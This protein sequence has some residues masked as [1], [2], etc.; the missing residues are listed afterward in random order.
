MPRPIDRLPTHD[1]TQPPP[2]MHLLTT[3]PRCQPSPSSS[4][5]PELERGLSPPPPLTPPRPKVQRPKF[6]RTLSARPSSTSDADAPNAWETSPRAAARALRGWFGTP[7]PPHS[8]NAGEQEEYR[9]RYLG[10]GRAWAG[11]LRAVEDDGALDVPPPRSPAS[12]PR[13]GEESTERRRRSDPKSAHWD[14]AMRAHARALGYSCP[15]SPSDFGSNGSVESLA[16]GSSG[17]SSAHAH[18]HAPSMSVFSPAIR[19]ATH[20]RPMRRRAAS[21]SA[22]GAA[23]EDVVGR[24]FAGVGPAEGSMLD[25]CRRGAKPR[26]V[27]PPRRHEGRSPE[28][29]NALQLV[30]DARQQRAIQ[31]LGPAEP[32]LGTSAPVSRTAPSSSFSATEPYA[33]SSRDTLCPPSPASCR[34][35]S[36]NAHRTFRPSPLGARHSSSIDNEDDKRSQDPSADP[37]AIRVWSRRRRNTTDGLTTIWETGSHRDGSF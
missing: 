5:A 12:P 21:Y 17:S 36:P 7:P 24:Y 34:T 29:Q 6:F 33:P 1:R 3:R 26:P 20:Y 30:V 37:E 22:G 31:P 25:A 13:R 32:T 18:A 11:F 8:S 15:S 2:E 9:W 4:T 27:E 10:E 35:R 16:S 19:R 23:S 28:Q 14:A